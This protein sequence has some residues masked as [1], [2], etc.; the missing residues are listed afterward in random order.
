[1]RKIALL[2][3][4]IGLFVVQPAHAELFGL[5]NGRS[6]DI[7]NAPG[8]SIEAGVAFGDFF[9][10]DYTHFGIRYNYK[11]RP[12]LMLFGNLGLSEVGSEDGLS[13][14]IG[15]FY[16][17]Q[18]ILTNQDLALKGV[19]NRADG[20]SDD[21]T[22]ISFE[23]LISGRQG[24]GAN[25]D[26]GWY[27]NVGLHRFSGGGDSETEIGIGGGITYPASNGEF[28]AGL[29]LIEDLIFGA[30]FRYFLQ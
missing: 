9:D 6:A 5:A 1:M 3:S 26:I 28:F 18:G 15:A 16:Q 17:L 4:C 29:D 8:Q 7:T 11:T 23:A 19:V 14:G 27:G 12:Q 21:V 22:G 20:D 24:F 13:F 25:G 10:A 30:G 2:L